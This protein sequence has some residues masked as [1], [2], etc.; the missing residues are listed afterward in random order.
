MIIHE[1]AGHYLR[2]N[3]NRHDSDRHN[4]AQSQDAYPKGDDVSAQIDCSSE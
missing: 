1:L 2:H 4:W 3:S